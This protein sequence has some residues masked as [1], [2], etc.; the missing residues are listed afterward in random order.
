MSFLPDLY[1]QLFGRNHLENGD[2]INMAEHGRSGGV[3]TGQPFKFTDNISM[4]LRLATNAS[5]TFLGTANPGVNT[6]QPFWSI[7]AVD[8]SGNSYFCD[9]NADF[10]NTFINLA[11]KTFV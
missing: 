2:I 11:A 6:S 7:F 10:D 3:S 8:A 4:A 9:G 5:L 1:G